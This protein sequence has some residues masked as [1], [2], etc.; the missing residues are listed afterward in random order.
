M[1][2]NYIDA[3]RTI[4]AIYEIYV[5]EDTPEI[6]DDY[7][8]FGDDIGGYIEVVVSSCVASF[9][10]AMAMKVLATDLARDL[11]ELYFQ[12][13]LIGTNYHI[14]HFDAFFALLISNQEM[15]QYLLD[16]IE[17]FKL[18][19]IKSARTMLYCAKV[20]ED[21]ALYFQIANEFYQ[22]DSDIALALLN[23]YK[24]LGN[25]S[26]FATIAKSL[27]DKESSRLY[28]LTI[29]ENINKENYQ[30]I[31]IK[32]LRL[33]IQD[34]QSITHYQ[35]LR[36][37][38]EIDERL[39]FIEIFNKFYSPVFYIQLLALEEQ[40]PKILKFAQQHNDSYNIAQILQPII[41]IYPNESFEIIKRNVTA[42]VH[43]RGRGNYARAAE[44][45]TLMKPITSKTQ[46][47]KAL[48]KEFYNHQPRLP[49]LRDEFEKAQLL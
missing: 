43:E 11:I 5:E 47:L 31:Y 21:D 37:Y 9:N 39:K 4:L 12:R 40:Y 41:T 38:L 2:G 17:E 49:A 8:I 6:E 35:L 26:Q 1:T 32:A 19:C 10:D 20:I 30:E 15:A 13:H 28:T 45:L 23:K 34:R 18:N 25:E 3:F 27:L 48:I 29:I 14:D 16:E 44:I 24:M 36:E 22:E 42:L 33:Y 46:E 7:Y